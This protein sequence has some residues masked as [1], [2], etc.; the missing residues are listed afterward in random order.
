MPGVL[1]HHETQTK[2]W[3]YDL[4]QPYVHYIPVDVDLK[5]LRAQYDWAEENPEKVKRIAENANKFAEYLLSSEYME[6]IYQELFVDYFGKLIQAYEH[7]N[8][9]WKECLE[10]YNKMGLQLREVAHCDDA[11]CFIEWEEGLTN[12]ISKHIK[13]Q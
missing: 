3:F 11:S 4:M 10:L 8:R 9:S 2:D 5:S 1:F 7:Q 12:Q 13:L 6:S